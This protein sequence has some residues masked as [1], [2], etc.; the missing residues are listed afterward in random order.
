MARKVLVVAA[1]PDDEILGVGGTIAHHVAAGD[2]V[3]VGIVADCGV[4]RY[5]EDTIRLVRESAVAAGKTLGVCETRFGGF[6]DQVLD[7]IPVLKVTRWV[8]SLLQDIKPEVIYCHHRGDINRDHKIV[9]EATLTAARPYAAPSVTR[10]LSYET[11]SATEWAGPYQESYFTPDVFVD[12][13]MHLEDKLAAM[14]VYK[15]EAKPFPHPRSPESLRAHA[16]YWGSVVG[17][18]AAEAFISVREIVH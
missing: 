5:G 14:A 1:H 2:T 13:S 10:I 11:P 6:E 18:A 17:V 3:V 15:T 8:E 4:A 9:H 16:A 7:A 12:I